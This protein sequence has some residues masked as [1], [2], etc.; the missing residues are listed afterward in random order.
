M[1]RGEPVGEPL[2]GTLGRLGFRHLA[3]DAGEGVAVVDAEV[4]AQLKT[5]G[6]V[7][8]VA[9]GQYARLNADTLCDWADGVL[10][11]VPEGLTTAL[12][13]YARGDPIS[14]ARNCAVL[15]RFDRPAQCRS[16]AGRTPSG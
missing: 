5:A 9:F 6:V 4:A 8:V 1:D 2:P 13:G 3:D 14:S 7:E 10:A 15:S 16:G 11:D 12:V